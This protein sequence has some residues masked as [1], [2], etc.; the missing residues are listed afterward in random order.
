MLSIII[1]SY[2]RLHLLKRTLYSLNK[3]RPEMDIEV[4]IADE[5]S[6][7]SPQ[8]LEELRKYDFKWKYIEC[9]VKEFEA[10][11]G[12]K[13]YYNNAAWTYNIGLVQSEGKLIG[14]LGNDIILYRNAVEQLIDAAINSG[15]EDYIAFSSTYNTHKNLITALDE[16]GTNLKEEDIQWC[17]NNLPLHTPYIKS[18]VNNYFSISPKQTLMKINGWRAEYINGIACEDSCVSRRIHFI[19][20]SKKF[21]VGTSITFH[22]WHESKQFESDKGFWNEGVERN[23]KLFYNFDGNYYCKQPWPIGEQGV[24]K[25]IKNF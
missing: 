24:R 16:Y 4:V 1:S 7:E 14:V 8:I 11:T 19:P 15:V 25:I 17:Y 10:K 6:G 21:V 5:L 22:Q 23:R 9:D 20:N 3:N 2:K 18:D 12:L 13:K